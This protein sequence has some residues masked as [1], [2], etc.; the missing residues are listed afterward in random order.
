M[1]KCSIVYLDSVF[2]IFYIFIDYYS[3]LNVLFLYGWGSFK[4]IM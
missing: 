4:E 2:D 1:V 3:F